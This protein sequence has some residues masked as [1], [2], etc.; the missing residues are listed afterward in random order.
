MLATR[1]ARVKLGA[2]ATGDNSNAGGYGLEVRDGAVVEEPSG[3]AL[4]GNGTSEAR[5]YLGTLGL[6]A[7]PAS[8]VRKNDLPADPAGTE[9][10]ALVSKR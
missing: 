2:T 4:T 9:E 7:H 10:L 8:G 3:Q 6:T 5:V 1:G